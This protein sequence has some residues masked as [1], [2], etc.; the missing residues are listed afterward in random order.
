MPKRESEKIMIARTDSIG[1]VMLTLPLCTLIKKEKP[2]CEIIFIGKAYTQ[3]IVEA[4]SSIDKF[5]N[6]EEVQKKTTGEQI[7][8]LKSFNATSILHVFPQKSLTTLAWRAGIPVRVAT[9]RR[10]FTLMNC[11]R[12]IF[13][14]RKKSL[15]HEAQL[16][17]RLLEGLG[18]EKIPSLDEI[19]TLYH[20]SPVVA[21][22][23]KKASLIQ[24]EKLNLILHP[25]SKGSAVNW[26]IRHFNELLQ[27]L[28]PHKYNV[29]ITGT[30]QEGKI[31]RPAL[32]ISGEHIHDMTGQME[33]DE[34]I[35]F[36]GSCDAL[37]AASTGPLHIAAALGKKAIGLYS[38]MR[39]I[40]TGRWA[41]VGKL[42]EFLV[43]PTH[44]LA[45]LPLDIS[46]AAVKYRLDLF[47]E[48]KSKM[49]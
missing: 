16:N 10:W 23:E 46:P 33:L 26:G 25:L 17:A 29:F 18:I 49:Q 47:A 13:F 41:P 44:P 19:P 45:G 9:G 34:L 5:I 36:I 14:S 39:P 42:S 24:P 48:E 15:L 37:V 35:T 12:L 43:A 40:D 38:P 11:N 27:Q 1:D 4:C 2:S 20:F 6:W 31:I 7:R 8:L 28:D 22:N 21:L 32:S 30:E 3:S